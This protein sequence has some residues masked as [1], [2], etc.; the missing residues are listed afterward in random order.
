MLTIFAYFISD[1]FS[2]Q[3]RIE[4]LDE[5]IDAFKES[6]DVQMQQELAAELHEII[7]GAQYWDLALFIEA[8]GGR[9][10]KP[11]FAELV[12]KYLYDRLVAAPTMVTAR[13]LK[14]ISKI[15]QQ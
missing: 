9:Q 12:V 5:V 15:F 6:E 4:E 3:K 8:Q 14:Q 2:T 13:F 11:F 1:Y 10:L 7:K